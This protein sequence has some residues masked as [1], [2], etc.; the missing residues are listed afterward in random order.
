VKS[1]KENNSCCDRNYHCIDYNCLSIRNLHRFLYTI[2][3][4]TRS[5]AEPNPYTATSNHALPLSL[6]HAHTIFHAELNL[7]AIRAS[8]NAYPYAYPYA[9]SHHHRHGK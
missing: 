2:I 5:H 7:Y 9:N 3:I 6:S 4:F 1:D 8:S